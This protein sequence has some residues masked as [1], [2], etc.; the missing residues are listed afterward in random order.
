MLIYNDSSRLAEQLQAF[1]QGQSNGSTSVQTD[2]L[3]V[4]KLE[5][6][7]KALESFGKRAYSAE[8]E[9]QRTI[10]KDLLDAAQGFVNCNSSP[11][12]EECDNA[13]SMTVDRLRSV[14]TQWKPVL[15]HSAL[16]QSIGSLL[17]SVI[18]KMMTDV[19][20]LSDIG[21]EESKKLRSYCDRISTI[22]DIFSH[23]PVEGEESR[24]MTGVYCPNW[25]KF[26]YLA[27]IME[28]S[29][30]DIKYL[31]TEGELSLEFDVEEVTDLILALFLDNDHRR[32]A[33]A[34]IRRSG[35]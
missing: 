7:I 33:I 32:R 35:R 13:I 14:Y 24:D 8:M 23:E 1:A 17:S 9:S 27:E 12:A 5:P 16:L 15:S 26:Q 34:E 4:Q 25:F 20:D 10:L 18:A 21:D 31:W 6:G 11:Y 19:E 30:A 29:L 2:P 28:S 3:K 22:H